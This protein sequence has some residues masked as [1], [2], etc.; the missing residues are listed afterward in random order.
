MGFEQQHLNNKLV[1]LQE[2]Y[3]CKDEQYAAT[4]QQLRIQASSNVETKFKLQKDRE[5]LEAELDKIAN[6][7]EILQKKLNPN[8]KSTDS[9]DD[10]EFSGGNQGKIP[11][12][13]SLDSYK[14]QMEPEGYEGENTSAKVFARLAQLRSAQN[15]DI[16]VPDGLKDSNRKIYKKGKG[17][18]QIL[19]KDDDPIFPEDILESRPDAVKG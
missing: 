4:R 3:K 11:M 6:E 18:E 13:V 1:Q 5:A 12:W 7:I 16:R 14:L 8:Q 19:L 9:A 17:G 15:K 2:D 10:D